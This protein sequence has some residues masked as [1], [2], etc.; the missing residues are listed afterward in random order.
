MKARNPST[1]NLE[2]VYVK[3]LDS[4][5][6][7]TEVDFDGNISDIP[8]GWEQVTN[9]YEY[10]STEVD[11]GEIEIVN[12]VEYHRYR[13]VLR[14]TSTSTANSW[15]TVG[16]NI[17]NLYEMLEVKAKI[18][19]SNYVNAVPFK[20]NDTTFVDLSYVKGSAN[21]SY[22]VGSGMTELPMRV[23]LTYIKSS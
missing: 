4:M 5:P 18:D 13:K 21:I 23:E 19:R 20:E 17:T 22:R 14:F 7:G 6:V 11:T 16:T 1:G 12:N 3:A 9:P 10:S 15:T 8:A 2:T